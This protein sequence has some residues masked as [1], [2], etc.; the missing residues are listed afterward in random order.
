MLTNLLVNISSFDSTLS[1]RNILLRIRSGSGTGG[2]IVYSN[3]YSIQNISPT[4]DYNFTSINTI[5]TAGTYT[6]TLIDTTPG[7]NST[8]SIFIYG[9][10]PNGTYVSYNSSIVYPKLSTFN[11]L[12]TLVFSQLQNQSLST[13]VSTISENGYVVTP[14]TSGFLSR[15]VVSLDS[16]DSTGSR[17]LQ[18]RI[19]NGSG[20]SGT[21]LYAGVF[22]IPNTSK[23]DYS[24]SIDLSLAPSVFS[25]SKYTVTLQDM[26]IT[27]G[28]I[29]LH[30]INP[31]S[32]Y[33]T[34]NLSVYPKTSVY[35]PSFLITIYPPAKY[36]G[37]LADNTDNIEFNTVANENATTLF[38]NGLNSRT[39]FYKV[40]LEYIVLPNKLLKN[41]LGGKLDTHPYVYVQLFNEGNQGS[42][43]TIIS[44]N[45]NS[46]FA[47]F[48]VAVDKYLYDIP[49][50]FF[51]LKPKNREQIIALRPDKNIRFRVTLPDGTILV[52]NDA[53][54][55]TPDFPNPFLQVN[56]LFTIQPVD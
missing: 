31:S 19:R 40:G 26:S 23:T 48:K 15:V 41:T 39:S 36:D 42:F 33:Q 50:S 49:T 18:I 5:L 14:A 35:I 52:N 38:Y 34:Y 7:G 25:G 11:S 27:S 21:I 53:D 28:S 29:N 47:L 37:F 55:I 13:T 20:L 54:N 46:I 56:A 1:Y 2:T 44:N 30:G 17:D 51:T 4:N 22:S 8:G 10:T 16:F 6:V 12:L 24:F 9:I 32:I 45:P 43:K 3:T